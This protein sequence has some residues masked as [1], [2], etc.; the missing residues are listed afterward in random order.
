MSKKGKSRSQSSEKLSEEQHDATL[1]NQTQSS[2][3]S[4]S[5]EQAMILQSTHPFEK[6]GIANSKTLTVTQKAIICCININGGCSSENQILK[7]LRKHWQFIRKNSSK[8][9]RDTANIRLLHINF[10]TRKSGLFLFVETEKGS[11]IWKCNTAP[12][13]MISTTMRF[14]DSLLELLK[15][16]SEGFT[17]DEIVERSESF[18]NAPGFFKELNDI[19]P[20]GRRRIRA[21]LAVKLHSKEVFKEETTQ[22]WKME[23]FRHEVSNKSKNITELPEY[24]KRFRMAELSSDE[25]WKIIRKRPT[26]VK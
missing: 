5:E 24:L 1:V 22:K 19:D 12:E 26:E 15:S 2:S 9:Y 11:G 14:E 16:N 13:N 3:Q 4:V 20:E 23:M 8:D 10:R 6:A 7:F 17:I 25:L 18:I 21:M